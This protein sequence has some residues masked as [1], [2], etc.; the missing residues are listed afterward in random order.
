MNQNMNQADQ[1]GL[2]SAHISNQSNEAPAQR[3]LGGNHTHARTGSSKLNPNMKK[4]KDLINVR[5]SS[6]LAATAGNQDF[7]GHNK[8]AGTAI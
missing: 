8:S 5:E 1:S 4:E 3:P 7:V 6:N 2:T